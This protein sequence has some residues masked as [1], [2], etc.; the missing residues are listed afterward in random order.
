MPRWRKR[1]TRAPC[2][3]HHTHFPSTH[4]QNRAKSRRRAQAKRRRKEEREEFERIKWATDRAQRIRDAQV[5]RIRDALKADGIDHTR[6]DEAADHEANYGKS[7]CLLLCTALISPSCFLLILADVLVR[8]RQCCLPCLFRGGKGAVQRP[9]PA[10]SRVRPVRVGWR[11]PHSWVSDQTHT[12][13]PHPRLL[14]V[15][16]QGRGRQTEAR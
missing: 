14:A 13:R 1:N 9:R 8:T 10:P 2:H 3:H 15:P 16:R 6:A 7:R 11:R 4:S 5:Q 12:I